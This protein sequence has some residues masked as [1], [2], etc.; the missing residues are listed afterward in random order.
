MIHISEEILSSLDCSSL[1]SAA[2]A[3]TLWNKIILD[4]KLWEKLHK[5]NVRDFIGAYHSYVLLS[6]F[7]ILIYLTVHSNERL[8]QGQLNLANVTLSLV[9]P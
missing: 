6:R 5:K 2:A 4:G 3:S 1:I 9:L 8:E 7:I